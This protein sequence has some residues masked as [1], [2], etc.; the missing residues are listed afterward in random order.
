MPKTRA[1]VKTQRVT[2]SAQFVVEPDT[3]EP[4]WKNNVEKIRDLIESGFRFEIGNHSGD[5]D[6]SLRVTIRDAE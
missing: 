4:P 3:F 1:P 6:M 5:E 2:V